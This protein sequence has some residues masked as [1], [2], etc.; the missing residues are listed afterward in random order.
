MTASATDHPATPGGAGRSPASGFLAGVVEGYYGRT[1]SHAERGAYA[2]L[3]PALGLN[4]FLYCPK[5][6]PFL[7]RQWQQHWPA[8]EWAEL[9]QL[10]G[11]FAAAGIDFGVGLSP[12]A[13]YQRYGAA[14][15]R[16]LKAK[17]E[18]L[19]ELEAPLLAVLF[20]D[21]PGDVPDLAERQVEI[22]AD[23]RRWLPTV[24]LLMCPTYYSSDPVLEKHFGPMPA[25]YWQRLG[26]WLAPEVDIFWTGQRVCADTVGR[27][28]L[29]AL[30]ATFRRP[31]TLWDNYPVN[32]GALRSRHLYLDPLPGR[33]PGL[34]QALRGHFCNPMNQP[35]LSLPALAGL[36]RLH[37]AATLPGDWLA[38]QLG[39]ELWAKLQ[40]DAGR[41]RDPGLD[42]L[43]E[44]EALAAEYAQLDGPAAAE[45][46]G[47]L[48]GE[49]AFDPA[50]LTD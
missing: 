24:R 43:P 39:R 23:V 22:L 18:R 32:D 2:R 12:F 10:A 5:A 9:R 27:A 26:E 31:L 1:W 37:G 14:Q 36:G 28:E 17:L 4:A 44:R 33:E 7:R 15:R 38:R 47:W 48:R 49:Y 30:Q 25:H 11:V 19:A 45:V 21:M 35:W 13:L 8:G 50:C 46:A 41:F 20:D 34:G 40:A 6:D 3:M 29:E 42:G 16:Q